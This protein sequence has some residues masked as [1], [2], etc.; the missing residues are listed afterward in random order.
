L[1]L[2][3]RKVAIWVIKLLASFEGQTGKF[4]FATR[5]RR[6]S[7][8]LFFS[9]AIYCACHYLTALGSLAVRVGAFEGQDFGRVFLKACRSNGVSTAQLSVNVTWVFT[10]QHSARVLTLKKS[11]GAGGVDGGDSRLEEGASEQ[12]KQT[13][14]DPACELLAEER[15]CI[16]D[17]VGAAM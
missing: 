15:N 7:L 1:K 6:P 11:R 8:L 4:P 5:K 16:L 12:A 14:K 2:S 9:T 10:E 3:N 17:M 13:A